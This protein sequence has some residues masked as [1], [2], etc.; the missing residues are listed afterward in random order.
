MNCQH[1]W[2]VS[3]S[4]RI[5][6]CHCELCHEIVPLS[7]A[8]DAVLNATQKHADDHAYIAG[9]ISDAA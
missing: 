1:R 2:R 7:V 4:D 9:L 3:G 8:L 6:R 5:G